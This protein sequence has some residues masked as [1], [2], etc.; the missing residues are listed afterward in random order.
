MIN[1]VDWFLTI[2]KE[3]TKDDKMKKTANIIPQPFEEDDIR[4]Q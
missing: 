3:P 4:L 2:N 1:Y